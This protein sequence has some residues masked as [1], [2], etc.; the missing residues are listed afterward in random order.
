MMYTNVPVTE[1]IEV[2]T[3]LLYSGRYKQPPVDKETFIQ[4]AQTSSCNVLMSTP[5]GYMRQ[6]DG[7]AMG[8]PPAPHFANGWL[9]QFE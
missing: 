3:D 5:E 8:S 9:R 1:A 2:C 6:D 7:L 4:L